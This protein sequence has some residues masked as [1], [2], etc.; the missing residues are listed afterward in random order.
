MKQPIVL[1]L[2]FSFGVLGQVEPTPVMYWN[3]YSYYNPAMSG[4]NFKHE[5]NASYLSPLSYT[6]GN[7]T[8]WFLNYGANFAEK[9]GLGVNYMHRSVNN[10]NEHSAKLNYNYQLTLKNSDKLAFG[11]APNF[12]HLSYFPVWQFG[13]SQSVWITPPPAI[14]FNVDLG[15]AY[16]GEKLTAGLSVSQLPIY[17]SSIKYSSFAQIHG[18]LRYELA[19]TP[20]PGGIIFETAVRT[21]LINVRQDFNLGYNYKNLITLGIGY[22]STGAALM[23]LT[24]TIAKK[25]RIGYA[26]AH[27]VLGGSKTNGTHEF[28]LGLRIPTN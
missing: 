16:Y 23:N 1:I 3:N 5:A 24:G 26:Y 8:D 7:P 9:H 12:K 13:K 4:V 28:T 19:L 17:R 27:Q 11:I 18:N 22:R 20:D 2:L 25:Y 14:H 10:Y 6:L 15:L 21:D